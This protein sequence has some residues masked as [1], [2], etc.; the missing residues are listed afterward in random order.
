MAAMPALAEIRQ[1]PAPVFLR[2]L[3]RKADWG[4]ID[5]PLDE[6]AADVVRVV[7]KI[8][9]KPYSLF[10]VE[11]DDELHRVVIGLNDGR[12]SLTCDSDFIAILPTELESVGID[13]WH[14]TGDTLC[15]FA[16]ALHYD[17][18]A[19]DDQLLT[20]CR[21]MIGQGREAIHLT[22]G[23]TRPMAD[24]AQEDGCLVVPASPGCRVARC[25]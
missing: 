9:P 11:T 8:D 19:E 21:W 5:T 14:S 13:A 2:K 25:H 4:S 22:K 24:K 16:N 20:M 17:I 18:S 3:R 7:F 15:R 10:R 23:M 1:L 12:P 6:R